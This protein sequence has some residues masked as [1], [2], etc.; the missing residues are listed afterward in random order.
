MFISDLRKGDYKLPESV[1][2]INL[3]KTLNAYDETKHLLSVS[4]QVD[5]YFNKRQKSPFTPSE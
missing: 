3:K 1:I 5:K 2:N 4:G